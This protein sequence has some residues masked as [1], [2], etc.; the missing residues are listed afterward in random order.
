MLDHPPIEPLAHPIG[1][2]DCVRCDGVSEGAVLG[3]AVREQHRLAELPLVL[4]EPLA[5]PL[6]GHVERFRHG[7]PRRSTRP[8]GDDC[9]L[10]QSLCL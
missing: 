2:F 7:L 3:V 9:R 4:S 1:L 10:E 5:C 6:G 8:V